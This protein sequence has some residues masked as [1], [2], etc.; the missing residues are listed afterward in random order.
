MRFRILGPLDLANGAG[1]VSLDA[2][3]QRALLGVLL[4]HPNEAV[5]S[6]RLID[7]LWGERPPATAAKILQTYVSQLRR[8]VGA[9]TIATRP[10]GYLLRIDE[11]G[12]DATQFRRLAA[13]GRRLAASGGHERA[14]TRYRE[15]LALWRGPP[16]ADVFFESFARNEVERLE[17]ERISVVIDLIDCELTLGRHEEVVHELET[18]VRQYPLRERLRAQL[19]LA[20]YRSGR[21]ADALSV[22]RD[23]RRTLVDE[24]G[25]E[26]GR[27]LQELEKAILIHDRCLDAA[28]PPARAPARRLRPRRALRWR[29]AALVA[30]I[31]LALA[32]ALAFGLS[33]HQQ[34]SQRLEANSVGLIDAKSSRVTSSFPVGRA[35]SALTVAD[36][37]VWVA[38]YRDATVTRIDRATGHSV[39]IPV[40]GHPTGIAAVRNTV[41]VWT[42]EGLLVPIDPRYDSAGKALSFASEIGGARGSEVGPQTLGGRIAAG[43]GFLWIAAPPTTVIRADTAN[44]RNAL[45]IVPDEGVQGAISYHDGQV[46]VAGAY[47]VF[48]ITAATGIPGTGASVGV[49]RD[50]AFGAGSLWVVSGGPAHVGGVSQALRR[51]D[52]HTGL[53]QATIPVGS[54]PVAVAIAGGSVWV[55]ARTD[56]KIERVDPKTNRVVKTIAVG[57]KPIALAPEDDGVWAAVR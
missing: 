47:E 13:E 9:D 56:G 33:A 24:L 31:G 8:L 11:E 34:P 53:V 51:L 42:L 28:T 43:A 46:W 54:D 52:P 25:L 44:A 57:A 17:E 50:L 4:L 15:A 23:G 19:M 40:G 41:W 27:E 16:L 1:P 22:Y 2:P 26:P 39:T 10:P 36:N 29:A 3:K 38:N 20:L 35:P 5:S 49:V 45:P 55:A 14:S 37:S 18:L 7:E 30:T 12:L 21:Q 6:E 48:P 32:L